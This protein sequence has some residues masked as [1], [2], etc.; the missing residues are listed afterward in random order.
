MNIFQ[1]KPHIR[2]WRLENIRSSFILR[3]HAPEEVATATK[4]CANKIFLSSDLSLFWLLQQKK[5]KDQQYKNFFWWRIPLR[6]YFEGRAWSKQPLNLLNQSG[7]NRYQQ[8]CLGIW[9]PSEKVCELQCVAWVVLSCVIYV[10][11]CNVVWFPL[12]CVELRWHCSVGLGWLKF[13]CCCINQ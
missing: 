8:G 6:N 5:K 3:L 7:A 11:L 2:H 9:V 10:E 1:H 4:A 13:F 12:S